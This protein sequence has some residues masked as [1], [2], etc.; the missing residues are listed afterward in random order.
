MADS[1]G[2]MEIILSQKRHSLLHRRSA[3]E[4]QTD[5]RCDR[6]IRLVCVHRNHSALVHLQVRNAQSNLVHAVHRNIQRSDCQHFVRKLLRHN[7]RAVG[8]ILEVTGRNRSI[9]VL[10]CALYDD[11]HRA[12]PV[13]IPPP[14][15][16]ARTVE[17]RNHTARRPFVCDLHLIKSLRNAFCQKRADFLVRSRAPG[18]EKLLKMVIRI[19]FHIINPVRP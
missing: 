18:F 6:Q 16:A 7:L 5:C 10:G 4:Q 19:R 2:S 17:R 13:K 11:W 8:D 3:V 15:M 1:A 9:S 14:H 12:V